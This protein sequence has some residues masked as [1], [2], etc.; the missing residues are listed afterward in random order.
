M[1]IWDSNKR[2]IDMQKRGAGEGGRGRS[3]RHRFVLLVVGETA[4]AAVG[5]LIWGRDTHEFEHLTGQL[6]VELEGEHIG[7]IR[8]G[9]WRE[10]VA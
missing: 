6:A 10:A 4:A 2:T 1:S 5:L 3:G 7:S 8:P 9:E